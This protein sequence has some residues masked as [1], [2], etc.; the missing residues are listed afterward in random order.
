MGLF[1]SVH[2]ICPNCGY[3]FIEFQSKAGDCLC[4]SYTWNEV[5]IEIAHDIQGEKECCPAC[6]KWFT[7]QGLFNSSVVMLLGPSSS[8][9][10]E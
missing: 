5:P 2:F 1:D 10:N 6:E 7:P 3:K 8:L 9:E 4:E